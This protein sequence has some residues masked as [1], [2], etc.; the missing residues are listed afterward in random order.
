MALVW[1]NWLG[2]M[3]FMLVF[4]TLLLGAIVAVLRSFRRSESRPAD[5]HHI[6]GEILARRLARGEIDSDEYLHR[7]EVLGLHRPIEDND[8]SGEINPASQR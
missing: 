7:L 8:Q 1:W 2:M 5:P 6:A 3:L 4:W